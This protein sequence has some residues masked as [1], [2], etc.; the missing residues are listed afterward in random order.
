[1]A[2]PKEI[3]PNGKL[4][5][6]KQRNV[7]DG[8]DSDMISLMLEENEIDIQGLKFAKAELTMPIDFIRKK[9]LMHHQAKV[10]WDL[11]DNYIHKAVS[12]SIPIQKS[13]G[14][15]D[16]ALTL[17]RILD[18]C[19]AMAVEQCL[20]QPSMLHSKP[21]N[22]EQ[23]QWFRD[24]GKRS[25]GL[26]GINPIDIPFQYQNLFGKNIHSSN[27]LYSSA[28]PSGSVLCFSWRSNCMKL[29]FHEDECLI[30]CRYVP[31]TA[32]SMLVNILSLEPV[33]VLDMMTK[34]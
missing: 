26:L 16:Y 12:F 34:L 33:N 15:T 3:K 10:L 9:M 8:H 27:I 14:E 7:F 2:K 6:A 24:F 5:N 23:S 32:S 11:T 31:S 29:K 30:W 21:I 4:A 18:A 20:K 1:M 13:D 22:P 17:E 19:N 25:Y 28:V